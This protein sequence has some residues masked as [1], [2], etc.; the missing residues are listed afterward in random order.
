MPF[1]VYDYPESRQHS[2]LLASWILK[3]LKAKWFTTLARVTDQSW[4]QSKGLERL[5][6]SLANYRDL[7][8]LDRREGQN[9]RMRR[10]GI[11]IFLS[12]QTRGQH[13]FRIPEIEG[14][15]HTTYYMEACNYNLKRPVLAFLSTCLGQRTGHAWVPFK[16]KARINL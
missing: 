4:D 6:F 15:H 8:H 13:V 1:G 7:R 16:N 5:H 10:S 12:I 14:I 11:K 2:A 3:P 9:K